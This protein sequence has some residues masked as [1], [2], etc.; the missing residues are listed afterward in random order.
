MFIHKFINQRQRY[1]TISKTFQVPIQRCQSSMTKLE[2]AVLS[3][4]YYGEIR[5][6]SLTGDTKPTAKHSCG[7]I[8]LLLSVIDQKYG[9]IGQNWGKDESR[10]YTTSDWQQ[11]RQ[12]WSDL[13]RVFVLGWH[14]QSTGL[15]HM[16]YLWRNLKLKMV[17][18]RSSSSNT[19]WLGL[20]GSDRM[21]GRNWPNPG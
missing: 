14:C 17:V 8:M 6:Y 12:C 10:M 13:G 1:K 2:V 3:S 11:Q 19:I 18:Y 20:R 5:Y 7:S 16:E 4:Q 15:N 21:N 9:K